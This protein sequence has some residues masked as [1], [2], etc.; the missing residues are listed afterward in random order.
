MGINDDAP[1]APAVT[2]RPEIALID[3][4][5]GD[6]AD[7]T[8]LNVDTTA[9]TQ[10]DG[11]VVGTKS[12]QFSKSGG[13]GTVGGVARSGLDVDASALGPSALLELVVDVPDLTNVASLHVR[14]GT[15]VANYAQFEFLDTELAGGDAWDRLTKEIAAQT[16]VSQAGAG[17]DLANIR[18]MEVRVNFDA[19]VNTLANIHVDSVLVRAA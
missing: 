18:Y 5:S 2:S 9:L 6:L 15:D 3:D 19:A 17:L 7:W 16:K 12:I 11:H 8:A 14:L 4:G 13:T 10:E 1:A